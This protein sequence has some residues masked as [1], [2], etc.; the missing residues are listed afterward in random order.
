MD[1]PDG[2][3]R[4]DDVAFFKIANINSL[5]S[6]VSYKSMFGI[7]SVGLAKRGGQQD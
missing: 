3:R 7:V 5:L 4:A 1:V 2:I 6:P